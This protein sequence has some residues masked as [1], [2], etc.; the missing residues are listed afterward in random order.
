[1]SDTTADDLIGVEAYILP[2]IGTLAFVG[3]AFYVFDTETA[4][5]GVLA[6][7]VYLELRRAF[8]TGAKD[9]AADLPG[10]DP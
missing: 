1:M 7:L 2:A 3:A 9:K 5:R 10:V 6:G 8:V 4:T